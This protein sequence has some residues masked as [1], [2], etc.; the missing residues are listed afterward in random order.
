MERR[1]QYAANALHDQAAAFTSDQ[2]M[3]NAREKF[4]LE[5]G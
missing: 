4:R 1:S 5:A 3:K 2:R